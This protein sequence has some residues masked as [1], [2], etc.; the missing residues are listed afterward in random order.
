MEILV[1]ILRIAALS[2]IALFLIWITISMIKGLESRKGS[3][4][5]SEAIPVKARLAEIGPS[6]EREVVVDRSPFTIGRSK[7]CDLVIED[8]YISRNHAEITFRDGRFYISDSGSSNGTFLSGRR[9]APK[10]VAP[11]SDG[12]LIRIGPYHSFRFLT[13]AKR[14]G[15]GRILIEEGVRK[16]REFII[17]SQVVEIGR[18]PGNDIF[19]PEEFIS[20]RH[21][22]IRRDGDLYLISDLGSRNGTYINGKRIE[23]GKDQSLSNMDRIYL[24]GGPD[25][26]EKVVMLFRQEEEG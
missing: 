17:S 24:G 21:A 19:L 20:R 9:L 18:D 2:L 5:T 23:P 14:K 4:H 6:S 1:F 3:P 10:E 7:S 16:G 13:G 26:E 22:R 25:A 15:M 11:I 12:D 8:D